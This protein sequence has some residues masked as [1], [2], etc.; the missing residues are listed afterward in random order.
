MAETRS[1]SLSTCHLKLL[2]KRLYVHKGQ[3]DLEKLKSKYG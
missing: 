2:I 1:E 3:V